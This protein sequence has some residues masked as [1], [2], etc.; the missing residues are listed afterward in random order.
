MPHGG[1]REVSMTEFKLKLIEETGF[2]QEISVRTSENGRIKLLPVHYV[3]YDSRYALELEGTG[4][5]NLDNIRV[6]INDDIIPYCQKTIHENS[7]E[8]EFEEPRIFSGCFGMASV[9]LK[10]KD[11]NGVWIDLCSP[12]LSV[13]INDEELANNVSNMVDYIYDNFDSFLYEKNRQMEGIGN[14]DKYKYKNIKSNIDILT[15]IYEIYRK[16]YRYLY[17]NRKMRLDENAK[18]D[19]FEKLKYID[20]NTIKYIVTHPEE[21][22]ETSYR[23]GIRYAGKNYLPARTCVSQGGWTDDI[24]ENRVIMSFLRLIIHSAAELRRKLGEAI[25]KMPYEKSYVGEFFDTSYCVYSGLRVR[26]RRYCDDLNKILI[27]FKQL[28]TAYRDL[29]K[30]VKEITIKTVPQE[31]GIFKNVSVYRDI[32]K[33]INIWFRYGNYDFG[34]EE[35]IVSSFMRTSSIYEYFILVK[36]I[37]TMNKMGFT[38]TRSEIYSY[39]SRAKSDIMIDNT[40][41]FK[42]D[43][44]EVT[45]YFQPYIYSGKSEDMGANNIGIYR[46]M[47]MSLKEG[48][49]KGDHY[50]PDYIM[51]FSA[52]GKNMYM[53][54]DAK[55]S[56]EATVT[57]KRIP[58]LAFK[59]SIS[60]HNV[61]KNDIIG[62]VCAFCGRCG[63]NAYR[64]AYNLSDEYNKITPAMDILMITGNDIEDF[65][66]LEKWIGIQLRKLKMHCKG[67]VRL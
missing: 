23:T 48:E 17:T 58:E 39:S 37:H 24:Y 36:L 57:N 42:K 47:N 3:K 62:G 44:I 61:S 27:K 33:K 15:G 52:G 32:F 18:I 35:T 2:T 45:L 5:Y 8:L 13:L 26:Y 22:Y 21:L 34:R 1:G 31:T 25:E 11:E 67:T 38:K 59:Y 20:G 65:S 14:I 9:R 43:G 56:R 19:S 28:Y 53:I 7:I 12:N 4:G 63:K 30:N 46:S 16:G 60:V 10:I 49:K 40:L 55:F 64:S 66:I 29:F 51:K 6:Y 54:L 41:Y 50:T